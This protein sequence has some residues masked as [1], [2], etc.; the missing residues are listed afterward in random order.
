[1]NQSPAHLYRAAIRAASLGLA[2]NL[3]L[4]AV[5]LVGGIV[6]Q[7]FALISDAVNSL[8]DS[9]TSAVVVF[10]LWVAQKPP[11][12]EHPY[13]HTRAEA[14][15]ASNVALLVI[16]S[17]LAVGWEALQRITVPHGLPPV[18]T[19]WIAGGNAIIKEG[20]YRYKVRVGKQ[21]G[22]AAIV[23]NAWDHRSD[24]L[25]S[26]A[27]LVGLAAV[28]WGGPQLIWA[29]EAAALFVVAAIVWSG[30]ELFYH[31]ASELMD[32]Q[33]DDQLV[34][35]I[36]EAAVAVEGV[37]AVEKLWVRKTGLE[38]LADIHIEVDA[39]MTVEEGHRIGHL[40]KDR[41][42]AQF[43]SLRDVLVHLEPYPHEHA[44]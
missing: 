1:L 24:A 2:I 28:R 11:D 4:G 17:A 40:V 5:K 38:Y 20:L 9:L 14:V 22:S 15:A 35:D 34:R 21:T 36:R 43:A 30:V 37:Q 16:L 10:A 42:V 23:A 33:A 8:G 6:S 7:S 41:L 19:L 25:C 31:S 39:R 27:V 18:W 44:Q 13:G 29:D 12:E 32:V 26:I 3:A